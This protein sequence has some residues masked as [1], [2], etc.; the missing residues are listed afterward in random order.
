MA[1]NKR[2]PFNGIENVLYPNL[3]N[4]EGTGVTTRMD[5]LSN[6][7]KMRTNGTDYNGN[8]TTYIYMAF[9]EAPLVGTNGVTAKAR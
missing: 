8:G 5:M 2:S 6:G 9:A 3:A 4:A 1:D 7:F